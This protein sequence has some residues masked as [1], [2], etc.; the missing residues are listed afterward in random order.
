MISSLRKQVLD[1]TRGQRV[2]NCYLYVRNE[3]MAMRLDPYKL[4]EQLAIIDKKLVDDLE[5]KKE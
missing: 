3:A 5:T 2:W 1:V 4:I